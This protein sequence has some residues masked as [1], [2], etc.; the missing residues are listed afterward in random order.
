MPA[1][2]RGPEWQA[3]VQLA[4]KIG[5]TWP[6]KTTAAPQPHT[7]PVQGWPPAQTLPQPPQLLASVLVST[8]LT[9][10]AV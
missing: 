2:G 1:A 3:L 6:P 5:W 8:Q 4:V 7:P 9:P 10:Q